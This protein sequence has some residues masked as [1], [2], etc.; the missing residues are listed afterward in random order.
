MT[1]R[2]LRAQVTALFPQD[3][4]PVAA[5]QNATASRVIEQALETVRAQVPSALVAGPTANITYVGGRHQVGEHWA[6]IEQISIEPRR[7]IVS[8]QG[9][10]DDALVVLKSVRELLGQIDPLARKSTVDPLVTVFDSTC[11]VQLDIDLGEMPVASPFGKLQSLLRENLPSYRATAESRFS[12]IR[13]RIHYDSLPKELSESNIILLDK[14]F[15]LEQREQSAAAE[16]LY[17]SQSPSDTQTHLSILQQIE[18][19]FSSGK[20]PT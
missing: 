17:Y 10:S 4:L 5:L 6:F 16:R 18:S 8:V 11:T 1:L 20:A 2:E 14:L 9:N 13:F 15:L 19:W 7:I 3:C 12:G